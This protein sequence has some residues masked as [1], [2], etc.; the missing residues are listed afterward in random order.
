MGEASGGPVVEA[1]GAGVAGVWTGE[2]EVD[3]ALAR[4]GELDGAGS[5]ERAEVYEDVHA[6]LA[7]TLAALDRG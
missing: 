5:E 6:R 1:S 2:R 7:A 3:A 4:L